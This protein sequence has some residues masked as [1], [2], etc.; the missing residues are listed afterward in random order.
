MYSLAYPQS[1]AIPAALAGATI[2][3]SILA[4]IGW[5]NWLMLM[6]VGLA[7]W[8]LGEYLLHRF[9]LHGVEPFQ[10]WHLGHHLHPDRPMRIPLAFSLVLVGAVGIPAAFLSTVAGSTVAF[11]CG[12]S[13]GFLLQE[14]VHHRLHSPTRRP[15]AWLMS[16]WSQHDF[17]HHGDQRAAF[18]TLTGFW[19]RFFHTTGSRTN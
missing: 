12:V 9:V 3:L 2:G 16:Q 15:G 5:G 1:L 8:T 10:R 6:V 4:P 17:H 11:S 13:M 7:S 18:G 14:V 19:D